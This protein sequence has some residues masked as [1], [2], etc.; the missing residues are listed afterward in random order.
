MKVSHISLAGSV[1]AIL[2]VP[3]LLDFWIT[4]STV[5]TPWLL[6][7]EMVEPVTVTRPGLVS[8]MVSGRTRPVSSAS[9]MVK[10]FMVE[11]GSNTSVMAR[12]RSCSPVRFWRLSGT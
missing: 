11:P 12:L 10:G 4:P 9:P 6:V 3:T 1:I 2:V 8:M 7:S 5:S